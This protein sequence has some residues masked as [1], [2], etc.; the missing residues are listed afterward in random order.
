MTGSGLCLAVV[1]A[2]NEAETITGVVGGLHRYA[3]AFDTLVIDDGSTDGTGALA[4][5]AGAQVI[6][7]PFNVG[8][9]G[10]VQTG[11]VYAR[12]HGYEV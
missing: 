9:G 7:L 2:Y 8:I 10:A 5:R 4:R 11:F 3:P 12:D 1:P 6:K